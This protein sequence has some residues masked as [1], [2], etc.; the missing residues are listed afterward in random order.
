MRKIYIPGVINL[1][2]LAYSLKSVA[3]RRLVGFI[4]LLFKL[5]S[6][7]VPT[8]VP[9]SVQYIPVDKHSQKS[10]GAAHDSTRKVHLEGSVSAQP[11]T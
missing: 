10:P 7:M 4:G 9:D 2:I 6:S 3:I 8:V 1:S 5:Q 11:C